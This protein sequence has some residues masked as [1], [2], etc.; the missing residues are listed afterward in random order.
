MAAKRANRLD[1]VRMTDSSCGCGIHN[2]QME[3][4]RRWAHI[5]APFAGLLFCQFR[6][7]FSKFVLQNGCTCKQ[8]HP[9]GQPYPTLHPSSVFLPPNCCNA[10]VELFGCSPSAFG[11]PLFAP[12]RPP[13]L[14]CP[15]WLG[16]A[17]WRRL[18][19]G[20][21]QHHNNYWS[22]DFV[23]WSFGERSNLHPLPPCCSVA[24]S[25]RAISSIK[26]RPF[27]GC[28]PNSPKSESQQS[29]NIGTHLSHRVHGNPNPGDGSSP[30]MAVIQFDCGC[31]CATVAGEPNGHQS[32]PLPYIWLTGH[33]AK[34]TRDI[35]GLGILRAG[36]F[37]FWAVLKKFPALSRDI[38]VRHLYWFTYSVKFAWI[39]QYETGTQSTGFSANLA[40][41]SRLC[42]PCA[43]TRFV[44]RDLDLWWGI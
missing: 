11:A 43:N 19:S 13:C 39:T 21:R 26:Y 6:F 36:A 1:G 20:V 33:S 14:T 25:D 24:L 44:R 16:S 42:D 18:V 3:A 40:G 29:L 30:A 15:S 34:H 32:L 4:V 22:F 35:C 37:S 2:P 7:W 38:C 28:S 9:P 23:F 10:L 41:L 8:A 17:V 27:Q 31:D 5:L 12:F